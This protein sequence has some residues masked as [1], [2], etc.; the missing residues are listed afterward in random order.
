MEKIVYNYLDRSDVL[1]GQALELLNYV[2]SISWPKPEKPFAEMMK[3]LEDE[4]ISLGEGLNWRKRY[5]EYMWPCDFFYIPS[6]VLDTVWDNR[7]EAYGATD[8]W[9]EYCDAI[10][11]FLFKTPGFKHIYKEDELSGRNERDYEEQ[12]LLKDIIGEGNAD[13]VEDL[14]RNY[15]NTY[16]YSF[17]EYT[18]LSWPFLSSPSTNREKVV[19]AWKERGI[20]I[21]IPSDGAWIDE[22]TDE[23][24]E[25]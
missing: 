14:I 2:Y 7:R 9:R 5:G 12:K 20:D 16:H 13:K 24:E 23:D 18:S 17:S 3:D 4:R 8:K 22:L 15:R 11:D 10:L 6:D 1:E 19:S 21:E 25:V